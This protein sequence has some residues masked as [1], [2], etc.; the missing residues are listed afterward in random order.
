M[1]AAQRACGAGDGSAPRSTDA[2]SRQR[3]PTPR[4]NGAPEE[5]A[6]SFVRRRRRLRAPFFCAASRTIGAAI[7]TTLGPVR[8]IRGDADRSGH[9][10]AADRQRADARQRLRHRRA[11]L[12]DG[13][14]HHP[15]HQLRARRGG[16]DRRDGRLHGHR[17]ARR[18]EHGPAAAR[19]RASPASLA[20]IPVCMAVG[21]TLER[22]A[23]RPLRRA[24]RLA[25]LITAIGL[26]IILQHLAMIIWSRNPLP[27]P[28]DRHHRLVPPHRQPERRDDHQR[29]DRDHRRLV[30]DDGG[31][32][33]CSSTARSSAS[34]C[35]RRAEPAGRRA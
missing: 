27:Y 34:R 11:G 9:L 6:V 28:A 19:D 18:R 5:V 23:Y 31:A 2:S 15:A 21:Y 32:A 14:R 35:A 29:A 26:S 17:R 12:H 10:P 16:D 22:V 33:R 25:P 3:L 4:Q 30:R 24:P 20:A 7:A 8:R 1:A 13:V